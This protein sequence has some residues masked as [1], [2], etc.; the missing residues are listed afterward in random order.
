MLGSKEWLIYIKDYINN[1]NDKLIKAKN[2]KK[3]IKRII[4]EQNNIDNIIYLTSIYISLDKYYKKN[5]KNLNF[6][7]KITINNLKNINSLNNIIFYKYKDYNFAYSLK[8]NKKNINSKI[9]KYKFID[10]NVIENLNDDFFIL[11]NDNNLIKI[12]K[13]QIGGYKYDHLVNDYNANN[14]PSDPNFNTG[15]QAYLVG[16]NR[17]KSNKKKKSL[18]FNNTQKKKKKK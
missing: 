11:V 3:I 13:Q 1:S 9:N 7:Y 6:N 5:N 18:F 14:N 12:N 8:K 15:A 4:K 2:I 16:F 17:P 10:N